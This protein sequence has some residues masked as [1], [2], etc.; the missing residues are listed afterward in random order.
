MRTAPILFDL[1]VAYDSLGAAA[2]ATIWLDR[3]DS[4]VGAPPSRGRGFFGR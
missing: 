1:G 4:L 3:A 2:R